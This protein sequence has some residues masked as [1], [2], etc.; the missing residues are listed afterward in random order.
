MNKIEST[1]EVYGNTLAELGDN[2]PDIVVIDADLSVSTQTIRFS[3]KFPHRFINVGCAEQNLI[4]TASGLALSGKTVFASTYAIFLCRAW[5]QIR[6]TIAYDKLNVKI[7]V[8]HAGLSNASDGA[9]HQSLEDIAIMRVIPNMRV[10][11]P[12]DAIQT[13]EAVC[14]EANHKGPAYIRL[15][16]EKTPTVFENDYIFNDNA[17]EL[18]KGSDVAII[19][20]GSMVHEALK[21]SALLKKAQISASVIE[22]HTIKPLDT[23]SILTAAKECG[24]VLTIEEHSKIGG[25][26]SAVAELLCTNYYVPM[27]IL[28]INDKF[29]ESGQYLE[30]LEK[31]QILD[32]FIVNN[33]KN[34]LAFPFPDPHKKRH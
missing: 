7:V 30:L 20:T 34:L 21:A 29:G 24:A 23:S 33:V 8:T 12:S 15:N 13:R 25:L 22:V 2:N 28:G 14:Y 32:K 31:N 1:R 16:R 4:G 11:V 27:K 6:N 19:A 5:E 3:K 18:C 17:I 26:G 9:S 10:I